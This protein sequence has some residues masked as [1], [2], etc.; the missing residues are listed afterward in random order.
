MPVTEL[1]SSLTDKMEELA[2]THPRGEE[3]R[4][5]AAELREGIAG[6]YGEPQTITV[7]RFLGRWARAR[8]LWCEITG[9]S[10]I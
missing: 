1:G 3:L 8:R 9:E 7:Q 10:L 4:K 6:F 2:K 5:R